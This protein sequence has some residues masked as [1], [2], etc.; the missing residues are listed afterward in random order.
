MGGMKSDI[1]ETHAL[2][3]YFQDGDVR[4]KTLRHASGVDAGSATAENDDT[5]GQDAG[6]APE[7]DAAAAEMFGKK[8]ASYQD[9]HAACDFT[10]RLQ[11]GQA[12]IHFD[13]FVGHADDPGFE[14]GVGQRTAGRQMQI[15][16]QN[17]SG[18]EEA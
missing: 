18:A 14:K 5:A 3:V 1:E 4:A 12:P 10:H 17:L 16:K 11:Q 7:Q 2:K 6:D 15:R 13:G 9:R 8:V